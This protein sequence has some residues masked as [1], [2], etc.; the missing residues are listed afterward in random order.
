ME[1]SLT[2]KPCQK[3]DDIC[4]VYNGSKK[5]G[6]IY[7]VQNY[8]QDWREFQ[9]TIDNSSCAIEFSLRITEKECDKMLDEE[10]PDF[11]KLGKAMNKC[12]NKVYSFLQPKTTK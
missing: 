9:L 5:I 10:S 7:H 12:I 1:I 8:S 4:T 11:G 3:E 2:C 6:H